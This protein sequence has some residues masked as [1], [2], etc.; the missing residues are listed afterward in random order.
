MRAQPAA[1]HD[2]AFAALAC[3][4][5]FWFGLVCATPTFIA[6]NN[7][8]DVV[9]RPES[10]LAWTAGAALLLSALGWGAA[11]LAGKR[12][13]WWLNR[14]LLAAAM[15][16][17]VQ[18]NIVHDLFYYGAFNGERVDF[19]SYGWKFWLEWFGWL[20]AFPLTA[21]LL[22]RLRRLPPWLPALPVL[23]FSLL[24][25]PALLAPRANPAAPDATAIAIDDPVFAFSS[26]RNL[27]HL[28]PDGFQGDVVRQALQENPELAAEFQGFTL[29]TDH[30]GMYQGTAPAA[31]TLLTGKPFDLDRG[32]SYEWVTPDVRANSYPNELALRNY[33]VDYVPISGFICIENADSCHVRPFNDMKA[34]GYFRHHSED[35]LYSARLVADLTLFRLAP[36]LLKERIHNGGQWFLADTTLDG[37][38]PWPDPVIREWVQNFRV[39]DDRPVY[40]WY[41]YIGTHIPAKWGADCGML[42]EPAEGRAAY[43]AQAHCVLESIAVLLRRMKEA[44]VYDQTAFVIS[45][46]H[47]HNVVPD[48]L[49]PPPLNSMLPE[50]MT[51]SA[52]P[53]LLVK[54]LHSREP[55]Q[56]SAAPT[57]LPDIAPTALDLVEI[58]SAAPSVFELEPGQ[59]RARLFQQYS[60]PDFWS[61]APIPY[62]EYRVDGPAADGRQ[63]Q[64]NAIRDNR[65]APTAFEPLNRL[66]G[67]GFV[68]G[69]HLR[70][71]PGNNESSWVTGRQ[72]A[73]AIGIDE[74]AL[75]HR[76]ELRAHFPEWLAGQTF[77][78]QFNGGPAWHSPRMPAKADEFWQTLTIPLD[79][80]AQKAGRNFISIVFE[81]L[82][83]PP[84]NDSWRASAL[85]ESIK[86]TRTDQVRAHQ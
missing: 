86:V 39:V 80:A 2:S 38:S 7:P 28:L 81:R 53:A 41:H 20:A 36:M 1:G 40:K 65:S 26:I 54:R 33:Q 64:V 85:V 32:F 5:A 16:F 30:L 51:G 44:G 75:P 35:A 46:D 76:L 18:G 43:V 84:E 3:H 72:L 67:Q 21:A 79:A 13:S 62:V 27:V 6:L 69:A 77:T 4:F 71:S 17:A 55:L 60:I 49:V 8:E 12:F 74:P 45:G 48:D 22:T 78:V 42:A 70:K 61:G 57:H 83:H 59:D 73:F 66:T 52:R 24:L 34:R 29:F 23:S 25:G 68:L 14:C 56:F 47:G 82:E 11:R 37:S 31:Y 58:D 9:F 50:S 19:R 15:V 63:W 10:L